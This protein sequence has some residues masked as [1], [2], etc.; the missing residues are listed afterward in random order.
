[1]AMSSRETDEIIRCY[2]ESYVQLQQAGFTEQLLRLD[3]EVSKKLI[4][5][6]EDDKLDN[7]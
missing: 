3:N 7:Q 5:K 4:S 6:I 2:S 1:M